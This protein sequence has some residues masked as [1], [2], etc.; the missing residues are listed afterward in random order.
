MGLARENFN[1]S[2]SFTF[3]AAFAAVV[4]LSVLIGRFF[5]GWLCAFGTFNDLVYLASRK[6]FKKKVKIPQAVDEKLKYIKYIVLLGIII[7][8]WS[9][10]LSPEKSIDPWDAF[11]QLPQFKTMAPE[12]P[13]AFIFL[14]LITIGAMFIE[15]F[16]C[17]YLCPLGAIQAVLSKIK[18]INIS[19]PSEKCGKCQLCTENCPMGINLSQVESVESGECIACLKCVDTCYRSNPKV[20]V[21]KKLNMQW[22]SSTAAAILVFSFIFWGSKL[23]KPEVSIGTRVSAAQISKVDEA[24]FSDGVYNGVGTGF[25]PNLKVQVKID[26]GKISDIKIVSHE[27]TKGYYEQAFDVVPKEIIAAQSP[28][29]DAVSGATKSS[30][31]IKQAVKDALSKARKD[32]SKNQIVDN[33][34]NQEKS[35]AAQAESTNSDVSMDKNAKLKDGTYTGVGTGYGTDL[36]VS[37]TIKDGKI[38]DIQILSN[39]E[40]P[41]FSEQAFS[42]VPK[43][44]IAAQSTEV[45]AVSGA[46]FSSRGIMAAVKNALQKALI[47]GELPGVNTSGTVSTTDN[48]SS[49]NV[50]DTAANLPAY[51]GKGL[52]KDGIYTGVGK[53]FQPNLKVSVTVKDGKITD[54]TIVSHNETTGFYEKPFSVVP[55]EIISKQGANVDTV[56]G[57]T[58]SSNGIIAA[59]NDALKNA[60]LDGTTMVSNNSN[61]GT[62]SGSNNSSTAHNNTGINSS[63]DNS[64]Q[65]SN[66]STNTNQTG[67]GSAN[68]GNNSNTGTVPGNSNTN[69]GSTNSTGTNTGASQNGNSSANSSEVKYKDG[70]YTGIGS[71]YR[72]NLKLSVTV[73]NGKIVDIETISNRETEDYYYDAFSTVPKEIISRQSTEVDVVA[74]ATYSSRGIMSAVKAALENAK[75]Q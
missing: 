28:D 63:V 20:V 15:R 67:G 71:G 23:V 45:D 35:G 51:T 31:G 75:V 43:E 57:A 9:M 62:S 2:N 19:K 53:G 39:N 10:N 69:T 6:I 48:N 33:N 40:T 59:V 70:I 56:S 16:F 18:I 3:L 26:K 66:T 58:F 1:I 49:A 55:K 36:T 4:V 65:S 42:T 52:Y 54:I 21:F 72:S 12:I 64:N 25:R 37:V 7:F 30:N 47:S 24:V 27:E 13:I 5:C 38:T 22:Y 68:S 32:K 61:N 29:V 74:G 34:E 11:A 41:G 8:M 60:R 46:T 73:K 50:S 44:I 14:A 17:R